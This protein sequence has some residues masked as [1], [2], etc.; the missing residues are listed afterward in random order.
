MFE[1]EQDEDL[2]ETWC[3]CGNRIVQPRRPPPPSASRRESTAAASSAAGGAPAPAAR[4]QPT[5]VTFKRSKTGTIRVSPLPVLL[6]RGWR[7]G[8]VKGESVRA[9][10]LA[11]RVGFGVCSPTREAGR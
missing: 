4:I 9:G 5:P 6:S 3:F 8:L 10:E 1:F 2:I 11:C 7:G